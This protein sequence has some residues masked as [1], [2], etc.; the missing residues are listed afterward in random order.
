MTQGI[1][2]TDRVAVVTAGASGLGAYAAIS[3]ARY[4]ADV[5]IGDIDAEAAAKTVAEVEALGRRALFVETNALL[6]DQLESL[7]EQAAK[8]FGRVD[9]LVNNAGGVSKRN[10]MDSIEKSW[11]KHIDMNLVS[12]LAA[13]YAA[14]KVM[15]EGKR[16]G[17]IINVSSVEGTRGAPGFAVYA[18]CKAGMI[19]FTSSMAA[20][21]ADDGIRVLA[22]APDMVRTPG[23][24]RFGAE[25]PETAAA[26][27]RY[28][29]LRRMGDAEEYGGLVAFLCSDMASYLTGIH[30]RVDGGALAATGFQRSKDTGSWEL[31]HP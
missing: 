2:L 20:E 29:P 11:R 25:T 12:M 31:L 1:D 8:A 24:T 9:I 22:L 7:V 28:I 17:V 27:E 30:L 23:I 16:G 21:L 26:R 13:T 5:V 15:R 4:G 19:N 3:L 10:F 6:T 18:A 14:V